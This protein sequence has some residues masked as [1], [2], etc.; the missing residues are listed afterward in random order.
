VPVVVSTTDG[1]NMDPD[2][3]IDHDEVIHVV[4][5]YKIDDNYWK[6]Y[7]SC[8]NDNGETWSEAYDVIQNTAL[9][10][11]QPHIACDS[12]NNLY[13]TYDY[14]T[15]DPAQMY[16]YMITFKGGQWGNSELISENM[17]GSSYNKVI[18]DNNNRLYIF[19]NHNYKY[20]YKYFED[21]VWSDIFCPFCGYEGIY[22]LVS[23]SID[24]LNNIHWA[25]AYRNTSPYN[26]KLAY[27][28]YKRNLNIWEEPVILTTSNIWVGEDI[29]LNNQELPY[30][31]WHEFEQD[32]IPEHDYTFYKYFDGIN[33]TEQEMVVEDPWEQQIAIDQYNKVHIVDREKIPE[34]WQLVH[35]QKINNEW[36]GY[37]IDTSDVIVARPHLLFNNN[38]LLLVYDK[39]EKCKVNLYI[40]D[41]TGS[42][43][44]QLENGYLGKGKYNYQW[45]GNNQNG[46][47]VKNGMYLCRLQMGR[48]IVT[49]SL[50]FIE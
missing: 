19:W 38:M 47:K 13:V 9:W 32:S 24:S 28:K 27:F 34:G 21:G 15:G 33:W 10:M 4:W 44:K 7:Y 14:N 31:T 16:V 29:N 45:K 3:V 20:Y 2:M 25:G 8:S 30:I 1:Y 6:I 23:F 43:I 48:K 41:L 42:L 12:E 17:P 35:H 36:I 46:G 49:R 37:V 22:S 26:M 40:I 18:V 50:Q 11:S 5:S 39:T